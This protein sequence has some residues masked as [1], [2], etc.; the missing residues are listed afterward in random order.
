[1]K[2]L[3]ASL[4]V[5]VSTFVYS[6]ELWDAAAEKGCFPDSLENDTL[7][8]VKFEEGKVYRSEWGVKRANRRLNRTFKIWYPYEYK[9]IDGSEL[10]GTQTNFVFENSEYLRS[11]TSNDQYGSYT[12]RYNTLKYNFYRQN[13]EAYYPQV[14]IYSQFKF[15]SLRMTLRGIRVEI[16]GKKDPHIIKIDPI[17]YALSASAIEGNLYNLSYEYGF[18]RKLS[19]ISEITYYQGYSSLYDREHT[20]YYQDFG[21][22]YYLSF[23][24]LV[25]YGWFVGL[26]P[27]IYFD[28]RSYVTSGDEYFNTSI[29]ITPTIGVQHSIFKNIVLSYRLIYPFK[30]DT[31]SNDIILSDHTLRANVQIGFRF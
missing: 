31:W 6:Q 10:N 26:S 3:I 25:G 12:N 13:P 27:A 20:M 4:F 8:V 24:T 23:S 7:L 19:G 15:K 28:K 21:V 2:S 9:L 14:P 5:L 17:M 11:Y 29:G 18:N 22:K 1:M 30:V 16:A